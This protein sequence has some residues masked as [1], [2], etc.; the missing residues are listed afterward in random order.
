MSWAWLVG[1]GWLRWI[2]LAGAA[3]SLATIRMRLAPW[4]AAL[5]L[6]LI[7]AGLFEAR[8]DGRPHLTEK[9]DATFFVWMHQ[10]SVRL[11]VGVATLLAAGPIGAAVARYADADP[12]P[13]PGLAVG[14]PVGAALVLSGVR[15][16]AAAARLGT[17]LTDG[18]PALRVAHLSNGVKDS[19]R[20]LLVG[21]ALSAVTAAIVC[22]RLLRPRRAR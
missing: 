7:A 19:E 11:A 1:D 13:L 21:V 3:V 17:P 20:I 22:A 6:I 9:W 16:Y 8:F 10:V 18:T 12:N 14:A 5:A 2:I 4:T 15:L